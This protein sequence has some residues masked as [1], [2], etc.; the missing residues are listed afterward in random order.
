[1]RT[2]LRR[3]AF[4]LCGFGLTIVAFRVAASAG[5]VR[6]FNKH[7]LNPCALWA[8]ARRPMYYAVIHHVGRHSGRVYSTPLVAKLTTDGIIIPL[9]YGTDTDW[10]LNVRTAGHATLTLQGTDYA[11]DNPTIVGADVAGALVPAATAFVWQRL[12]IHNYLQ[13][14]ARPV[15][16]SQLSSAA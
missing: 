9:P 2:S 12:G 14:N 4:V 5:L 11:V 1:V 15:P 6:Q 8:V 16:Q 3:I 7:I 13:L 10:C